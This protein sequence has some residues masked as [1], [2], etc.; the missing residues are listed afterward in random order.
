M[1]CWKILHKIN[2][3]IVDPF[4]NFRTQKHPKKALVVV[5]RKVQHVFRKK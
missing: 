1:L 2:F 4:D 3:Q 5:G